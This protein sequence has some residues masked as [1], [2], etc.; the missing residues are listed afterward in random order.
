MCYYIKL[1]LSCCR[2][3]AVLF[4]RKS[5]LHTPIIGTRHCN[6]K[7][8]FLYTHCNMQDLRDNNPSPAQVDPSNNLW[9]Y[10]EQSPEI[11]RSRHCYM[12]NHSFDH[13]TLSKLKSPADCTLLHSFF[14]SST[15]LIQIRNQMVLLFLKSISHLND[16]SLTVDCRGSF[17]WSMVWDSDGCLCILHGH[18]HGVWASPRWGTTLGDARSLRCAPVSNWRDRWNHDICCGA[19]VDGPASDGFWWMTVTVGG[20]RWLAGQT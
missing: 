2:Y 12:R 1:V 7:Q 18:G 4:V 9:K 20:W 10:R 14:D 8:I 6:H 3:N 15:L 11:Q 5:N 16:W 13:D 19:D 17:R